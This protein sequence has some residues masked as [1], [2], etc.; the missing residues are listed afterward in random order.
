[1][2]VDYG[3][4]RQ[5]SRGYRYAR[6]RTLTYAVRKIHIRYGIISNFRKYLLQR[7]ARA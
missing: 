7:N 5:K 3:Y 4:V 2:Y 1:M 6:F